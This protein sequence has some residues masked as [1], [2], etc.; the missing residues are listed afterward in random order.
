MCFCEQ[1][2]EEQW[3]EAD[4]YKASARYWLRDV[5]CH[6][7]DTCPNWQWLIENRISRHVWLRTYFRWFHELPNPKLIFKKCRIRAYFEAQVY[8][9]LNFEAISPFFNVCTAWL[10]TL[11]KWIVERNQ[12]GSHIVRPWRSYALGFCRKIKLISS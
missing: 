9:Q 6:N 7:D 4:S 1:Q 10:Y 8:D 12:L 11:S 2:K 5:T 3:K